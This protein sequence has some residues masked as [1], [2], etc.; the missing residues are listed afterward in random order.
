M[1]VFRHMNAKSLSNSQASRNRGLDRKTPAALPR[2]QTRLHTSNARVP[3]APDTRE[4]P[5][6]SPLAVLIARAE[7]R[8]LLWQ[9]GELDLH[10]AVDELQAAAEVSG[11]VDELGQ[12]GVQAVIAKAFGGVRS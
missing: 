1:Q 11:L 3:R 6:V 5:T 4:Q 8:A 7:A 10:E 9:A 12:D 2:A